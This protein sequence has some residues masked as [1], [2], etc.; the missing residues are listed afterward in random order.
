MFHIITSLWVVF[1][2]QT[3]YISNW[4]DRCFGQ[5][6]W[7]SVHSLSRD[8]PWIPINKSVVVE[9]ATTT[10]V[11]AMNKNQTLLDINT[12]IAVMLYSKWSYFSALSHMNGFFADGI[13][14]WLLYDD[15]LWPH[16]YTYLFVTHIYGLLLW[17][18]I[19]AFEKKMVTYLGK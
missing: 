1:G 3:L 16:M 13:I 4:I 6:L 7:N 19:C 2:L 8:N 12:A 9:P 10:T 5:H 17:A 15:S 18:Y 11:R 14:R